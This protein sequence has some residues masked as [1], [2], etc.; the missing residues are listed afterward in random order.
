M[1]K[2]FDLLP[3]S[4]LPVASSGSMLPGLT[5]GGSILPGL[6]SSG[7]FL[8]GLTSSACLTLSP[9][10][11]ESQSFAFRFRDLCHSPRQFLAF[12]PHNSQSR[13]SIP[14]PHSAFTLVEL[15]VVIS[16]IGVLV[17]LLLPAVQSAREAARKMT[18]QSNLKQIGLAALNFES[19]H[20]HLPGGG[21]GYQWQGFSDIGGELG[22]PGAWTYS[23]LPFLE[24]TN[25]YTMVSYQTSPAARDAALRVRLATPVPVYNCPS[26]RGGER[27]SVNPKCATC[28][29]PV[30]IVGNSVTEVARSDYAVN[31][32][33]GAPDMSQL[34]SWPLDFPGPDDLS[35]ARQMHRADAWPRTPT[36]WTGISWLRSAVRLSEVTDGLSHTI[37]FGEKYMNSAAYQTGKDWGDNETLLGGFN[38]DNH[39]S[40]HPHW[41]YQ[42]DQNGKLSIGSFGS[43]HWSGGSFVLGDGSVQLISYAVDTTLFRHLGNRRDGHNVEVP[44]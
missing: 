24:Q 28:G 34:I 7:S 33:D 13:T 3:D 38:N 30:G 8:P 19:T 27:F 9:S 20:R 32:G 12:R 5:S 44:Q 37:M 14:H 11:I 26:R 36:D 10:P 35:A 4:T 1:T 41:P 6:T 18:C 39:R 29:S 22:Q 16:I 2:C 17:G 40:T 23:L 25:L 15:L 43:A 42:R 31:A 21:W